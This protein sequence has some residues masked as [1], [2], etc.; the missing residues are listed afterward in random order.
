MAATLRS[1]W[2]RPPLIGIAASSLRERGFQGGGAAS[3]ALPT[4]D[5]GGA[6]SL[7]TIDKTAPC[8]LPC[9]R[10]EVVSVPQDELE[11][12]GTITCSNARSKKKHTSES[13]QSHARGILPTERCLT[14][15]SMT[16]AHPPTGGGHVPVGNGRLASICLTIPS[17][18]QQPGTA[19]TLS[20]LHQYMEAFARALRPVTDA[21][22]RHCF[23]L[24]S[25]DL[26][27]DFYGMTLRGFHYDLILVNS[28]VGQAKPP[29][30]YSVLEATTVN[31]A[32]LT[33]RIGNNFPS[34]LLGLKSL[35][36][37]HLTVHLHFEFSGHRLQF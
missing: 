3:S 25:S 31:S 30:P 11:A 22:S 36:T 7:S 14:S 19:E 13:Q 9:P 32:E 24:A 12:A 16:Q 33:P 28:G 8:S 18:R 26:E 10:D 6:V 29:A 34:D 27:R 23:R 35:N 20:N 1:D 15:S 4:F 21:M 17:T 5:D 37:N 2:G